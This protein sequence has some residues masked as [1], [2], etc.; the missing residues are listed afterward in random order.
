[1]REQVRYA[2]DAA[3]RRSSSIA[4]EEA[5]PEEVPEE[6]APKEEEEDESPRPPKRR[7]V[8]PASVPAVQESPWRIRQ[9]L[10]EEMKNENFALFESEGEVFTVQP[11][12]SDE[13]QR[14]DVGIDSCAATSCINKDAL[15]SWPL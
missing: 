4:A 15:P 1:M 6:E 11:K 9:R 2:G 8:E 5:P 10:R 12:E 3:A 13:W 7:A 14:I